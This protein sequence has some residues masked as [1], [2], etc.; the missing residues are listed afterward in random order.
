MKKILIVVLPMTL[1]ACTLSSDLNLALSNPTI[2]TDTYFM[3]GAVK[4]YVACDN[5]PNGTQVLLGVNATG[6]L[7]EA[8]FW[9]SGS[10]RYN[11]FSKYTVS[12]AD[13][14]AK[15]E[16]NWYRALFT[17]TKAGIVRTPFANLTEKQVTLPDPSKAVGNFVGMI[18][19]VT[20]NGAR[21][22]HAKT[23]QISVYDNC[24][25]M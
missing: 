6:S 4:T 10:E 21:T 7:K 14:N 18:E 24:Q 3:N 23:S 13:E 11:T 1:A 9:I 17:V 12:N 20:P 15:F 19:G 2:A 22:G 16:N 8:V 5:D 25:F